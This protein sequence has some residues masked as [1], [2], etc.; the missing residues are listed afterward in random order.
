MADPMIANLAVHLAARSAEVS[1]IEPAR[2]GPDRGLEWQAEDGR[3]VGRIR[4]GTGEVDVPAIQ[5]MY[6]RE[7]GWAS[8]ASVS[9]SETEPAVRGQAE[10]VW[11]LVDAFDGL[12]VNR[13]IG[14][15][16]NASKA[17][18]LELISRCGFQVPRTLVTC[19]PDAA[20]A[21]WHEMAGQVIYKSVSAERS[22]V[23]SLEADDLGRLERIRSCPLQLQER[24]PGVDLRVHVVG[25]RV[26]ATEVRS[27]ASD[28]RY[29]ERSGAERTMRPVELPDTVARQCVGLTRELGLV[30][31]GVDLRRTP[32]GAYYCFEVNPS[33]AYLWFE[34]VTGQRI[35]EALANLLCR[36]NTWN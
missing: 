8:G 25:E 21:F 6:V 19:D 31:S 7:V 5:S 27:D 16:T 26:F 34:D 1:L 11:G 33:P 35:G 3:L 4:I 18:Q 14:S 23:H 9:L 29:A 28:Y 17:Y 13:R 36:G 15:A 2:S 10:A 24:I 22:I 12:V 32:Q 30:L 20:S